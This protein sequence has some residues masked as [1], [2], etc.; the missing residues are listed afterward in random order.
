MVRRYIT[1]IELFQQVRNNTR[2][3]VVI[4]CE[5]LVVRYNH[6]NNWTC[7]SQ[8]EFC[9]FALKSLLMFCTFWTS[10]WLKPF[11]SCESICW[12][13]RR[14]VTCVRTSAVATSLAS[15]RR[16]TVRPCWVETLVAPTLLY[17]AKPQA[18]HPPRLRL[19]RQTHKSISLGWRKK[20]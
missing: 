1:Y 12:S 16:W 10:R 2:S 11:R 6:N 20:L 15:R 4:L 17:K 14:L 13:L 8:W 9:L 3:I 18:S 5:L 7:E 19:A